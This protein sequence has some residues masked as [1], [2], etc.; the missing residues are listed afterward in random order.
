MLKLVR[1][2]VDLHCA[3]H[4]FV[5]VL[6]K[7]CDSFSDL[8]GFRSSDVS[9]QGQLT[10]R[11]LPNMDVVDLELVFWRS[12]SVDFGDE[13]VEIKSRRGSLHQDKNAFLHHWVNR[14]AN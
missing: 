8:L 11:D 1:H 6:A 3:V 12:Q 10:L 2:V 4:N 13:S 7:S 9:G 14:D 5:F